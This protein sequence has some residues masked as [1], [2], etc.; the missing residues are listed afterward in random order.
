VHDILRVQVAESIHNLPGYSCDVLSLQSSLVYVLVQVATLTVL[1]QNV[2][3]LL[4]SLVSRRVAPEEVVIFNDAWM[5]QTAAN[6]KLFIH[7]LELLSADIFVVEYF[8]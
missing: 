1:N 5:L 7:L 8:L 6:P 2:Q 3:L 4:F